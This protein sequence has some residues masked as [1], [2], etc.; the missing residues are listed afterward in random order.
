MGEMRMMSPQHGDLKTVWDKD[1]PEE[2]EAAR[3]QFNELV[4]KKNYLAFAV[5]KDG[6][7]GKKITDFDED[8][9][10]IILSPPL[11]GG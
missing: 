9:E 1:K 4:G 10:A 3:N 5:K 11:K 8:A 6:T 7:K 2:V